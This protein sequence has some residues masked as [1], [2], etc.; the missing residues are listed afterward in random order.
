MQGAAFCCARISAQNTPGGGRDSPN[1]YKSGQCVSAGRGWPRAG[2]PP[3]P[4]WFGGCH[5]SH[6]ASI[7]IPN[8]IKT[9]KWTSHGAPGSLCGCCQP[10]G[11]SCAGRWTPITARGH[12]LLPSCAQEGPG[13]RA[14]PNGAEHQPH[15]STNNNRG[16]PQTQRPGAG[17]PRAS[18]RRRSLPHKC[19]SP[20]NSYRC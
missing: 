14:S 17:L 3:V 8:L 4:A 10:R 20:I 1:Q 5:P 16:G 12:R 6:R 13:A 7:P 15:S 18:P 9:P 19:T 2:A 11:R